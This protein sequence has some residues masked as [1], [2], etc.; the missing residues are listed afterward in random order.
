MGAD[1]G[2]PPSGQQLNEADECAD[3]VV[4]AAAKLRLDGGQVA[5]GGGDLEAGKRLA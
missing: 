3:D 5:H 4:E 1:C 2:R